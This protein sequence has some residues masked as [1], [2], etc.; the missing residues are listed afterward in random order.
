MFAVDERSFCLNVC[1]SNFANLEGTGK[2]TI[3]ITP[4]TVSIRRGTSEI[5]NRDSTFPY[6][7]T[8]QENASVG[9]TN[10]VTNFIWGTALV[11]QVRQGGVRYYHADGIGSVT[12]L[13]D[14]NGATTDVY[15]YE[16]FG[17]LEKHAG[18]SENP[19]RYTSEYFDTLNGL[20]YNRARWYDAGAGRFVGADEFGGHAGKPISLNKYIYA[21]SDPVRNTDPSGQVTLM[22]QI[23]AMNS[24]Q[25]NQAGLSVKRID[26]FN[27]ILKNLCK[28]TSAIGGAVEKLVGHHSLP[29]FVGG[30]VVPE[31]FADIP[32]PLHIALHRLLEI[33]FV[34][35]SFTPPNAGRAT[36][37]AIFKNKKEKLKYLAAVRDVS[38]YVD[39]ACKLQNAKVTE[40]K[41]VLAKIIKVYKDFDF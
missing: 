39:K 31:K 20:Q 11:E 6:P 30:R 38:G 14:E 24:N 35:N 17:A 10:T 18:T 22:D 12:A 21:N 9:V 8:V 26:T 40:I 29:K 28:S 34:V 33:S 36:F 37:Q 16:T 5:S 1:L 15:E 13:T 23:A 19:Y 41:P 32:E 7:Q 2:P 25:L 3:I 27:A 4:N